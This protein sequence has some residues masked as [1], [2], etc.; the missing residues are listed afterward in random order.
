MDITRRLGAEFFGAFWLTF[1]GRGSRFPA[2]VILGNS[3]KFSNQFEFAAP[4]V[5]ARWRRIAIFWKPNARHGEPGICRH[6]FNHFD[7]KRDCR[8]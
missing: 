6:A 2:A 8:L 5:R 1:A 7:G 4:A 3:Q